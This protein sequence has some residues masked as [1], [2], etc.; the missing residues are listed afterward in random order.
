MLSGL[1]TQ[2]VE[3]VLSDGIR[4]WSD[5]WPAAPRLA[6]L[7][8]PAGPRCVGSHGL[9]GWHLVRMPRLRTNWLPVSTASSRKKQ[10]PTVLK[11][12]LF[13]ISTLSVPWTVTQRLKVSWIEALR[14][15]W[16]APS[17]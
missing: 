7:A 8:S 5:R 11:V 13:S 15:Y 3:A 17:P 16:P 14:M 2:K 6:E 10:W 4:I 1:V 12:T 9:V